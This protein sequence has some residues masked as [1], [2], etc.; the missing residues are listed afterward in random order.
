MAKETQFTNLD[1]LVTRQNGVVCLAQ[2]NRGGVVIGLAALALAV[3]GWW[4]RSTLDP[5]ATADAR[6]LRRRKTQ[7]PGAGSCGFSC[8]CSARC[9]PAWVT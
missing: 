4:F 5:A 1:F 3:G 7:T 2:R 9:G 6:R 8:C